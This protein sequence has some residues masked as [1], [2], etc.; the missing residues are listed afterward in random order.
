MDIVSSLAYPGPP[1]FLSYKKNLTK[2]K[3][4]IALTMKQIDLIKELNRLWESVRPYM[5][6]QVGKLYGRQDGRVQITERDLWSLLEAAGLKKKAEV[7]TEGGLWVVLRRP[8]Q[9]FL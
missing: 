4:E 2:G 3:G 9:N 6:R 1:G 7:I 5:A 8:A